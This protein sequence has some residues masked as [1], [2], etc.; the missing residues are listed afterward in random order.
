[1]PEYVY[2]LFDYTPEH[3]DEIQFKAGERI[4][5]VERDDIYNDGWWQVS[6]SSDRL[7][8]D[9][10][11]LYLSWASPPANTNIWRERRFAIVEGFRVLFHRHPTPTTARTWGKPH[12]FAPSFN[13]C[14]PPYLP[15]SQLALDANLSL[16]T[17]VRQQPALLVC[18]R[19]VSPHPPSQS[20]LRSLHP[21][22]F[23][24]QSHIH[25]PPLQI[26]IPVTP[27]PAQPKEK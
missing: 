9:V 7:G 14:P 24:N 2:A 11:G 5:V 1:M 6:S 17:R 23:M 21:P 13:H 3:P 15:M 19:K 20:S 27:I 26:P 4:E 12:R 25:P 16:L 22:S 8:L 10:G 18:F